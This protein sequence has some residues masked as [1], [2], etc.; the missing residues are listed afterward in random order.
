[1][2]PPSHAVEAFELLGGG[3]RDGGWQAGLRADMRCDHSRR[4]PLQQRHVAGPGGG[5]SIRLSAAGVAGVTVHRWRWRDDQSESMALGRH[6]RRPPAATSSPPGTD[7]GDA[8]ADVDPEPTPGST[9]T[10][11]P[12][13]SPPAAALPQG[14]EPVTL[15]P[16]RFAGV[17]ID[18]PFWPMAVGSRWTY[19]ETDAEGTS[20]DVEVTV[21][22]KTKQILG[23]AATVVHD[24]LKEDGEVVEDTFDWYAQDVD[25]NLWYMGED[26]RS[27]RTARSRAPKARGRAAS[28]TPS[29]ASSRRPRPHV[30]LTYRQEYL[31]GQARRM[32]PQ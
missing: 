17:A 29:R 8:A 28:T 23:I 21:T 30:G 13:P 6:D 10:P 32:R 5:R 31:K 20:Q 22:D 3:Q 16:A 26:T 12:S 25:G 7:F 11:T 2:F 1:M 9:P 27:S 24:Q 4:D 14:T 19:R 15:D 18:N